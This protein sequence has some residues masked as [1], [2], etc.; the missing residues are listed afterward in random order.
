MSKHGCD[1]DQYQNTKS[2][3]DRLLTRGMGFGGVQPFFESHGEFSL[4]KLSASSIDSDVI[5]TCDQARSTEAK[6]L[7][8]GIDRYLRISRR[9]RR[10]VVSA[11]RFGVNSIARPAH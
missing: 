2:P 1:P 9:D 11:G 3:Y 6:Q 10:V 7:Y 8:E 5:H 4:A